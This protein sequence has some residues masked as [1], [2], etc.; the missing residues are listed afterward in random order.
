MEIRFFL[1]FFLVVSTL[2]AKEISSR[3]EIEVTLFK[4]VGYADIIFKEDGKNYE[5]TLTVTAVGMAATL[6]RNRFE[7]FTSRGKI[8][9][10]R[11]VPDI[12]IKTKED[13]K[14][15][16]TQTYYFDHHKNEIKLIEEKTKLVNKASFNS[17]NLCITYRDVNESSREEKIEEQYFKNDSLTIYLNAIKNCNA[18]SREYP[19]YAIGAHNDEN[20]VLLSYLDKK[21]DTKINSLQDSDY[22][23]NLNVEPFDKSD[24]IV[25]V[26]IALDS[27]GT[28]KE[29]F[30]GEVFWIGK[31]TAKRIYHNVIQ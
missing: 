3:Y 7:T 13:N 11:Y 10:G 24:T 14:R 22:L 12:F 23:Y 29:A 27:D 6:L 1:I 21:K 16:R 5:T 8:V 15:S 31:I 18:R 17:S 26:L 30:M 2:F 9:D 28:L 19:L 25:D 20:S 4:K